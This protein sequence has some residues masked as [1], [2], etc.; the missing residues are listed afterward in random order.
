MRLKLI[1]ALIFVLGV[2]VFAGTASAQGS[3]QQTQSA[4][5]AQ[6]QQPA[7]NPAPPYVRSGGPGMMTQGN[8]Q[9]RGP[10]GG[11]QNV[12]VIHQAP[13]AANPLQMVTRLLGAL[14]D[15]RVRTML[16]ITDQQADSLHKLVLDTETFTITTGAAIAVDSLELREL[17]R[18]DKPDRAAVKSKGDE[19]S[20]ATSDLISHYLDAVLDAKQILTPEQQKMIADY[21]ANG[22]P[23]PPPPPVVPAPPARR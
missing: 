10:M 15:S 1:A 17:L 6:G 2:S 14:D 7:A 21:L 22:A 23:T 4:Q 18:A 12:T 11:G 19:I 16:G 3:A 5:L 20:K 13:A 8:V 9:M